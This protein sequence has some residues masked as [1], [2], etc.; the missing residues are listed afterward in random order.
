M[1]IET[2]QIALQGQHSARSEQ[3][4]VET[5][6]IERSET[7]VAAVP[8]TSG[9]SSETPS[10]QV[11]LDHEV[12]LIKLLVEALSGRKIHVAHIDPGSGITLDS[13]ASPEAQPG[14]QFSIEYSFSEF[15][16]ESEHTRFRATGTVQTAAGQD[17]AFSLELQ[18]SRSFSSQSTVELRAGQRKDPLVLNFDAAAAQLGTQKFSFDL[19]ANGTPEQISFVGPHS[20]FLALDRNGNGVI[21]NGLEL[22]GAVSGD[23]FADLARFDEDG[24][25]F[26]DEGDSVFAR[27][28]A[29]SRS[30]Y[31]ELHLHTLAQRGIGALYLGRVATAFEL[32]DT[33]NSALGTVRT[34]GLYINED[35]TLGTMQQLDLVV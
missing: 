18:M 5:L 3:R 21:D 9:R 13:L 10:A 14:G 2:A 22:F 11:D 29:Y 35:F 16:S 31:G 33:S 7:A 26:I 19:D 20:A 8:V 28:L 15:Y 27:L 24:N 32:R 23:G 30:E 17:F 25:G 12:L 34:T 4:R 1:R 6:R